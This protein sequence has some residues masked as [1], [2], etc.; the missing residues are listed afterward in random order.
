MKRRKHNLQNIEDLPPGY[1]EI[2][3]ISHEGKHRVYRAR[4][5]EDGR[6][7]VLKTLHPGSPYP[8]DAAGLKNEYEILKGKLIPG[9]AKVFELHYVGQ[10]PVLV[11]DFAGPK[12][13]AD[14]L[15]EQ[16]QLELDQ[17]FPIA[18]AMSESIGHIHDENIIHLSV[19][20]NNVVLADKT[21]LPI[22]VG[23]CSA[24]TLE[25][26]QALPVVSAE[27]SA[28]VYVS[29]EQTGR[30][31]RAV[32]Q[33]SDLY[34]LGIVF[35]QMLTGQTPFSS[36]DPLELVHAHLSRQPVPPHQ[37]NKNVPVILSDIVL[38]LLEK[39]P[40]DR[41][42]S[43]YGLTQDLVRVQ[44]QVTTRRFRKFS[45]G[46]QDRLSGLSTPEKLYG[47]ERELQILK[48]A[49]C[50][51]R[52]Q[53][54]PKLVTVAGYAGVGKSSLVRELSKSLPVEHGFFVYGKFDQ[55]K[56][57]S[58]FPTIGQSFKEL[59]NHVLGEPEN[60]I[61]S[62][63][64][65]LREALGLSGGLI[66]AVLPEIE[67]LIGKQPPPAE[68]P[69][70]EKQLQF[71][72]VLRQFISAFAQPKHPLVIFLDDLQ[73]ADSDSLKL[74]KNLITDPGNL[75]LLIVGAYR[76]NEI[77][78]NHPLSL[79]LAELR[80]S[81]CAPEEI[82]LC[83]LA[84]D[85][86][87]ALIAD[88]LH[89][90]RKDTEELSHQ[91]YEK[92][93]GNPF[94][95]LQLLM[96]LRNEH[97]LEFDKKK[98]LWRWDLDQIHLQNYSDNI[99][100]LLL[101]KLQKLPRCTRD[102]LKV[103]AC[104]GSKG[105]VS[106]LAI[107]C[108][109]PAN[110]TE[111]DLR[112]AIQD[113]LII[114]HD[115]AYKFLHDRVQQAAYA[116]IAPED[117]PEEHLRVGRALLAAVAPNELEE[118]V[119]EVVN[120]L[121]LGTSRITAR[122]EQCYFARLNL[123]AGR[124][125][126]QAIAYGKAV[127]FFSAGIEL[128]GADQWQLDQALA[129]DLHFERAECF[130]MAGSFDEAKEHFTQ[131]LSNCDTKL[132]QAKIY[133][134]QVELY[135]AKSDL[136]SAVKQ[137]LKGLALLGIEMPYSPSGD[138]VNAAYTRLWETLGAR[139]PEDLFEL[140]L[141]TDPEM[142]A[143][144]DI[145]QSLFAAALCSDQ[146]LFLLCASNMVKISLEHGHCPASVLGYGFFAMGLA[147]FFGRYQEAYR[148]GELGYDLA[149]K[150]ELSKYKARI[151]FLFGDT[152]NHWVHHLRTNLDYVYRSFDVASK[153]GDVTFAG[154]CCN[155][156]AIDLLLLGHPLD[157]VFA[158]TQKYL[159]YTRS[160]NFEAPGEV[161]VGIQRLIQNMRGLTEHFSSFNDDTF[162]EE[163]YEP[164]I[165]HYS[166]PIVTCWYYIMMC[167]ARFM[168]GDYS[169][170]I[171]AGVKARPFLWSSLGHVQEPEYWYY[172]AL[173]LAAQYSAVSREQQEQYLTI[174]K[175]HCA[176]LKEWSDA[177]P[178]NY[179]N[180]YSLVAAE[181]ARLEDRTLEAQQFYEQAI[182]SAREEEY[183]QNEGLA[184][185]LAARFY[186]GLGYDTISG[187]YLREAYL[188]YQRWRAD[189]KVR[190][191]EEH[192]PKLRRKTVD[193]PSIDLIAVLKAAEAI[194]KE[195]MLDSL[196][197]TLM[198][199]VIESA[200][201][202]HG[203]LLLTHDQGLAV[204]AYGPASQTANGRSQSIATAT[205][206][207]NIPF[208]SFQDIPKS[209]IH[210]VSRTKETVVEAD[211]FREGM[212]V[213]DDYV[214]AHRSRSLLCLP[215]VK[216][217]KLVGILYLENNLATHVFTPDRIDLLRLLSSQIVTSLENVM[218]FDGLR[219]EIDG[220]KRIEDELRQLNLE[221]E[222]RVRE[223]TSE[224]EASN[225]ELECAKEASE[226]AN[227]AKSEFV[228]N[229]SHE[230]RTPMNAVIGM[231]D[232]L[233]RTLLDEHQKE[234][235]GTIQQSAEILLDLISDLLDYSKIEAGK[236][237][238][239]SVDFDLI[240][241]IDESIEVVA[242][243]AESKKIT[244]NKEISPEIP[245]WVK[246]DPAKVRQVLLNLLSNAVKFTER[247]SVSL[248]A[249]LLQKTCEN[250][251]LHFSV[252]DTGIGIAP[253]A[254]EHLFQAFCQAD[255][256]IT[257]RFGGTGLGLAISKRLVS[258]M[259]GEIGVESRVNEGSTF[260]FTIQLPIAKAQV[261]KE[262]VHKAA[263]ALD[264]VTLDHTAPVLVVEDN[265]VNRKLCALMLKELGF[266]SHVVES[267]YEAI[268]AMS[269]SQ[270]SLI[271]MDCQMPG[272]DGFE[273]T[274]AIRDREASLKQHTPIVALTA[275]AMSGDRDHCLASGMDDYLSKP[276]TL[277]CLHDV[278]ARWLIVSERPV[279]EE[280][281]ADADQGQS[282]A[283][284]AISR[285][286][287]SLGK[288]AARELVDEF[289]RN[290]R[291]ILELMDT[292]ILQHDAPSVRGLA[293]QLR[294]ATSGMYDPLIPHLCEMMESLCEDDFGQFQILRDCV[295]NALKQFEER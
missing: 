20:P 279:M 185:E 127:Q 123:I 17:F 98:G 125:A 3:L 80:Q 77:D 97:S 122:N 32:D 13:L 145:L 240:A 205:V 133:Q 68:L 25:R 295:W 114:R 150:P 229:V 106:T 218:L 225:A 9:T 92:T 195:V 254:M 143:A 86:L 117:L 268:K 27:S 241:T 196:L 267:G 121:N 56:N 74:M 51:V 49:F 248:K 202:Q 78:Q 210:Y 64:N 174:I 255:T 82:T 275:Q 258:L 18:I 158:D 206:I 262:R 208:E 289:V 28:L 239:A 147:R 292:A 247:G 149:D 141:M 2:E 183:T 62:W 179:L 57:E 290:S 171:E 126:K 261:S 270:F 170:S 88:T 43:A 221:L 39:S 161:I 81:S 93:Q 30:M 136:I 232:L 189:G 73:W 165:A 234:L 222:Q 160:V 107:A 37:L 103:A 129:F 200:G 285:L 263:L 162:N 116:L 131:L 96:T 203:V 148:F 157:K 184:N 288:E 207:T 282:G 48:G 197:R 50:R 71:N 134:M 105:K 120:Q 256:S 67:L 277:Q 128:L 223:R 95:A 26:Q 112:L 35:Y 47:R 238:L 31:N 140:P 192:Y 66:A 130:W 100:D 215:I 168:S 271:L 251:S 265:A 244:L 83:P 11:M 291:G 139:Q 178:E 89:T 111:N 217:S 29:P 253:E 243:K 14:L 186:E 245:R 44:K 199:V 190:Q 41:Y 132:Q 10:N 216:Q 164:F 235:L 249:T 153:T 69:P 8:T 169:K 54:R 269:T 24:M 84:A 12:T 293:H 209:L 281:A 46:A 60:H 176:Q 72:L 166:Q 212:F 15:A 94:F 284:Y 237:E 188:C 182:R 146:N 231:S 214:K 155:H 230:I 85:Q 110:T 58:L 180:K 220:R 4:R 286:E 76:D 259:K 260:W 118:K 34:A 61:Q 42:Q 193:H 38:R 280:P 233:S 276:V 138:C 287:K 91:I 7:V 191:M 274:R 173:A 151:E 16:R 273:T 65:Q 108:E 266:E 172:F 226:A 152:I 227:R 283:K 55:F 36:D 79:T 177:C 154:Y 6:S 264:L 204:R 99:V 22:F 272:L 52:Q 45:L 252:A 101:R 21:N 70:A 187:A 246:G 213:S 137:G 159:D 23:F 115:G 201:A 1:A 156:I 175:R 142:E 90:K 224:L 257:R 236:L 144:M 242:T 33:R 181:L 167:Q 75:C 124:K 119:F 59:I 19:N 198:Q 104:L 250:V 135:T 211:A 53:R 194:S 40:E 5:I 219:N 163:A 109:R 87:N 63:S 278:L 113:G 228:A 294:R 102:V